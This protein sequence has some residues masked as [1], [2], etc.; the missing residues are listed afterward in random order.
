MKRHSVYK[1]AVDGTFCLKIT[2]SHYAFLRKKKMGS[3]VNHILKV[4]IVKHFK[5]A[6][7]NKA[8]WNTDTVLGLIVL[9]NSRNYTW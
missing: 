4:I 9:D 8:L 3:S 7:R 6:I 1:L 5:S 2:A